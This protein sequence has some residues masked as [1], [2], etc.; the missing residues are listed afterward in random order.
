MKVFKSIVYFILSVQ[1]KFLMQGLARTVKN[2]N[3]SGK[4]K[5]FA[6]GCTLTFESIGDS[7]K[8]RF[9][10]ELK[11]ILKSNNYNPAEI[12]DY[13][14]KH[15]T[16]CFYIKS[17]KI[18]DFLGENE[19][20]IYPQKGIKALI[21]S[22]L[23]G[24]GLRFKIKECF[25]LKKGEINLFYFLY[26]IYN[27]YTFKNNVSGIDAKSLKV[28]NK[29]LLNPSEEDFKKLNLQEI[30]IL[31]DAIKQDKDAID[32]VINLSKEVEI[33]KK[34]FDKIKDKGANI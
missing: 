13:V 21:L 25:I 18:L 1:E 32:F 11:L 10:E 20:F 23:T 34:A 24:Q 27:W 28:L 6:N 26:H 17:S 5:F 15:E 2:N 30:N 9:G 7:E 3:I 14:N 33:Y 29:Y 8:Q 31:K 19:G 4:K 12:L 22:I 16:K